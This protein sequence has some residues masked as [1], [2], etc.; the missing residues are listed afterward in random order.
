M[1]LTKYE[2]CI[3]ILLAA[4][5]ILFTVLYIV[6]T[7]QVGLAYKGSILIPS[8]EEGR[9]VYSGDIDKIAAQF[10]VTDDHIVTFTYGNKTYGPYTVKE[11]PTAAHA[12]NKFLTGYTILD[13][14]KVFFR[15]GVR[16]NENSYEFY[17]EAGKRISPEVTISSSIG[18]QSYDKDGNLIDP[19]VPSKTTILRLVSG[20]ELTHKGNWGIWFAGLI[21]S[22]FTAISVVF[23]DAIFRFRMS[24]WIHDAYDVEPSDRALISR[25]IGWAL[26]ILLVFILF[27]KGLQ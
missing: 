27:T 3:L 10:V 20:P 9:T 13:G 16:K 15:G 6:T 1:E 24:L 25:Y 11:D 4:M 18:G 14:D 12:S 19:M 21:L 26:G 22:I 7:S 23:A 8:Y 17:D 2:K 5:L